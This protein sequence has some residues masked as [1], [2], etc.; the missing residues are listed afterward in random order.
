MRIQ[1]ESNA[2]LQLP[3][4]CIILKNATLTD[5]AGVQLRITIFVKS[6]LAKFFLRVGNATSEIIQFH[7]ISGISICI[8]R[9][10]FKVAGSAV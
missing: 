5:S 1:I 10:E 6:V 4:I 3:L 9:V 8:W 2:P 7:R